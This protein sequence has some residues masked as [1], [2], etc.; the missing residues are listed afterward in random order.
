MDLDLLVVPLTALAINNNMNC[1]YPDIIKLHS[2]LGEHGLF[3]EETRPSREK[4]ML[5][6]INL[7][8]HIAARELLISPNISSHSLTLVAP[9][10]EGPGQCLLT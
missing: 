2:S 8:H 6:L 4:C 10:Q 9:L 5:R 1:S 3:M 7:S